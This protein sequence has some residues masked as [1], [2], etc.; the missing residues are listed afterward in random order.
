[1][2]VTVISISFFF[3]CFFPLFAEGENNAVV[4]TTYFDDAFILEKVAFDDIELVEISVE[5]LPV[6]VEIKPFEPIVLDLLKFMHNP[7]FLD[8]VFMGRDIDIDWRESDT[9]LLFDGKQPR[10]LNQPFD[11]IEIQHPIEILAQF[12]NDVRNHITRTAPRLYR[13]TIDQLVNVDWIPQQQLIESVPMEQLLLDESFFA[14]VI[15]TNRIAVQRRQMS[16]WQNRASGLLQF[17]Q[18]SFSDNWHL[19]GND[20]FA[21][22]GVMSARFNYDNRSGVRWENDLEW[23]MGFNTVDGDSLRRATP[24]DDLLRVI[25]NFNVR[26]TGDFSY[27]ASMEFRTHFFNNPKAINGQEMRVRFLTPIRFDAGLGMNYRRNNLA[28]TF[29]PVSFRYIYLTL[30]EPTSDGFFINPNDFGIPAG[31]NQLS[32]FGSRLIVDLTDYRPIREL[33][34]RSRFNFFTNYERVEIDWE[35]TAELAINRF[36]ST[37]L[38][39]NPRFDNTVILAEDETARIQMRQMLTVGFS[40]RFL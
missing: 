39:L 24:N 17:S 2:K 15:T 14:P 23:R 26:A 28:V 22:L 31:E 3:V 36:F 7:L 18:T 9:N 29:S 25:S 6:Q 33:T 12:R 5:T 37:R 34:I 38:M 40:Y 21:L 20:F 16:H 32:E 13:T 19:G 11:P 1:V 8:L 10:T 30:G 4:D 27:N 35:I